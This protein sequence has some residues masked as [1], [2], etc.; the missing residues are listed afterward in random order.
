MN[1]DNRIENWRL[2][3]K[4]SPR[5]LKTGSLESNYKQPTVTKEIIE[6]LK[7]E[8]FEVKVAT[9]PFLDI[10]DAIKVEGAVIQLPKKH[11]LVLVCQTMYPYLLNGGNF[12]KTCKIIGISIDNTIFDAFLL[13]SKI[14][15]EILLTE[16]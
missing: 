13:E 1:I 11:K 15:L 2:C 12:R 16:G 6:A 7:N 8:V 14:K 9:I 3:F 5:N 4:D 10:N